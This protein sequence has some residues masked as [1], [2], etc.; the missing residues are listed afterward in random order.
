MER[1]SQA[2]SSKRLE[3]PGTDANI[4]T[5]SPTG[6]SEIQRGR[7]AEAKM[8]IYLDLFPSFFFY[9]SL[10]PEDEK[11]DNAVVQ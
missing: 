11:I 10:E 2:L 5:S 4:W 3:G 9:F 6:L 1:P 7:G 8:D